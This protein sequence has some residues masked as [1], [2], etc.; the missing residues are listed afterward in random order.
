MKLKYFRYLRFAEINF[1]LFLTRILDTILSRSR[2]NLL[3]RKVA[4][5]SIH[6]R[7]TNGNE[8]RVKVYFKLLSEADVSEKFVAITVRQSVPSFFYLFRLM[9][10]YVKFDLRVVLI[11]YSHSTRFPNLEFVRILNN[12]I[13]FSCV[14]FETFGEKSIRERIVPTLGV[15]ERHFIADDPSLRITDYEIVKSHKNSFIFFPFPAFPKR[16]FHEYGENEK[17]NE[18]CFFGAVDD[19]IGHSGRRSYLEELEKQGQKIVG[20]ISNPNSKQLR[21]SYDEML[22][23]MRKSRIGLNFSNHGGIGV[24]TNRVIETIASG[25]VL[26]STNEDVLKMIL[27]PGQDYVVFKDINSLIHKID[28][29]KDNE[30]VLMQISQSAIKKIRDYYSAESFVTKLR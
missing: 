13:H 11:D 18:I 20:Y 12:R 21:P 1:T 25:A 15:I 4:I 2:I 3:D 28:S 14:W 9:Y 24:V 6:N 7:L 22:S 26:F 19:S 30:L 29:M 8:D 17:Q 23:D 10:L 27:T 5:I 16:K